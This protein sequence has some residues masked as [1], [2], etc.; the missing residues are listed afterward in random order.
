M[1]SCLKQQSLEG[2]SSER[3]S[4]FPCISRVH[5]SVP[6]LVS[7]PANYASNFTVASVAECQFEHVL[8]PFAHCLVYAKPVKKWRLCH[9]RRF[10]S[11][12]PPGSLVRSRHAEVSVEPVAQRVGLQARAILALRLGKHLT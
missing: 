1:Y 9:L 11:R 5:D 4:Y 2:T 8:P 6:L 3:R 10:S 12:F 7:N